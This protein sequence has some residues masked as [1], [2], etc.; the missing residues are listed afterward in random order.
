LQGRVELVDRSVQPAFRLAGGCA[1]RPA[2]VADDGVC[3]PHRG[4]GQA[5]QLSGDAV[6]DGL[7]LVA[8]LGASQLQLARDRP[9]SSSRGPAPIP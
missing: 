9:R 4:L 2:G 7:R 1:Q 5:S 6:H 8:L 3:L